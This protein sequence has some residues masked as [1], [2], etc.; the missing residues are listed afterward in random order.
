MVHYDLTEIDNYSDN[1]YTSL[2]H[3]QYDEIKNDKRIE[4]MPCPI[5]KCEDGYI[6]MKRRT[7]TLIFL[8]ATTLGFDEIN[9][10]NYEQV[11]NRINYIEK[12]NGAYHSAKDFDGKVE[13]M[14]YT[15]DD[16]KKHIG[17]KT[18]GTPLNKTQ[19]LS[20]ISKQFNL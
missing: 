14:Y 15:L 20:R 3:E 9:E 8:M 6:Q 10:R 1:C 12:L 19:F 13:P 2:T 7:N 18:N 17:L 11:F 5:V 16:I 4:L